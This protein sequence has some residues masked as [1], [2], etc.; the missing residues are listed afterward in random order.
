LAE[1]RAYRSWL[2]SRI[3]GKDTN[4]ERLVRSYLHA[5]GFRFRMHVR[6]L[7]GTP[8]IVLRSAKTV[9]FVHGCYWHQHPRKGCPHRGVPRTNRSF[10]LRKFRRNVARDARR[11][12]ELTSEGWH[13]EVVWECEAAQL[14]RLG[15][16]ARSLARRQ[17]RLL[18]Q[19]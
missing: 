16:L 2:M 6:N 12:A 19:V 9:I 10:W 18:R 5:Q 1:T 7:P 17:A 14:R 4:P 8:D 3:R 15:R 13:V 11:R